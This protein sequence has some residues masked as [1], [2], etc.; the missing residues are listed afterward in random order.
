CVLVLAAAAPFD[1]ALDED[2]VMF[3]RVHAKMYDSS[4]E[5]EFRRTVWEKNLDIIKRHNLE[6]SLGIHTYTLGMNKYGDMTSDEIVNTMNGYRPEWDTS[7]K[8]TV[9]SKVNVKDL[10]DT[11]DWRDKGYVTP[12]KDQKQCVS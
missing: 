3:K 7:T 1:R 5:E 11:V 8:N 4:G 2:W 12:V 10:Q 9:Y 6:E